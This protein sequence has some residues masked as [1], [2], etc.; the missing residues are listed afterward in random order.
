MEKPRDGSLMYKV[1]VVQCNK[2]LER[3]FCQGAM[4]QVK[5]VIIFVQLLYLSSFMKLVPST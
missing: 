4:F 3:R 5:I 2:R 1:I